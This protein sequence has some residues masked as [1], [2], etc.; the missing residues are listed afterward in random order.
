MEEYYGRLTNEDVLEMEPSNS[1]TAAFK[2]LA[3]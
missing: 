2:R 1:G 3:S